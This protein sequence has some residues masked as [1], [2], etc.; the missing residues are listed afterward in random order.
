MWKRERSCVR[1]TSN[2]VCGAGSSTMSKYIPGEGGGEGC[3][4]TQRVQGRFTLAGR[5]RPNARRRTT[6]S[7]TASLARSGTRR[8]S[9]RAARCLV[10]EMNKRGWGKRHVQPHTDEYTVAHTS[11]QLESTECP[12]RTTCAIRNRASIP[13]PAC[14][15]CRCIRRRWSRR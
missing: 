2:V 7:R 8:K 13:P 11:A 9:C 3:G 6:R 10:L 5:A 1:S 12:Q 14:R 15:R 4:V